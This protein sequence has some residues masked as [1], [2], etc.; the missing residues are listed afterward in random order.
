[1]DFFSK[2]EY[3][4]LQKFP[5]QV[6]NE[7]IKVRD[8]PP[9]PKFYYFITMVVNFITR[10]TWGEIFNIKYEDIRKVKKQPH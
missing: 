7:G 1:M 2:N 5:R 9:L 8:V 4:V 6:S 3:K 10:S